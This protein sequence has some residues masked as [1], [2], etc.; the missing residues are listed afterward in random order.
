M[1][2][3]QGSR[4][5]VSGMHRSRCVLRILGVLNEPSSRFQVYC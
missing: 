1:S 5:I 4:F 2:L 3:V